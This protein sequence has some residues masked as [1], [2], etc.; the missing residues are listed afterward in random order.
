MKIFRN[1][2]VGWT[3]LLAFAGSLAGCS[4]DPPP[5]PPVRPVLY[6]EVQPQAAETVGRFA[7]TIQARYETTLGFRVGGR[8]A[9]RRVDVGSQVQPGTVLAELDPTDQQNALRAREGDAAR[10]E[11]QFLNAQADARRQQELFDRGVGAK[12]ALDQ[13]ITRLSSAQSALDQTRAAARQAQDRVGYG[14][15]RAEYA[16][17]VNA[18]H[19]E[20]GQVVAAGQ[21]VV[22]LARPDVKEA[23]FDLPASLAERIQESALFSVNAQLEPGI[24]T[25]GRVREIAPQADAATRTQRVRLTLDEA[26]EQF[27]LGTSVTVTLSQPI[28]PQMWLPTSAVQDVDGRLQVWVIDPDTYTVQARPVEALARDADR[29]AVQGD[30]KEGDRLVSAGVNLLKPGQKVRMDEG[31]QP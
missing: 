31:V 4:D 19:V 17:V 16:S 5:Q 12:A 14:T 27:H 1:G 30:L 22:T 18:W 2:L 25:V 26:P 23:V 10:S 6:V 13:A 9:Q 20:V 8:V 3:V 7:G 28:P 29:M 24:R 11:V 21:E 15:L